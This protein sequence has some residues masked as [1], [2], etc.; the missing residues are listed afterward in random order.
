MEDCGRCWRFSLVREQE[1]WMS[2]LSSIC[3]LAAERLIAAA[4]LP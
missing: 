4:I 1:T 3:T 2:G